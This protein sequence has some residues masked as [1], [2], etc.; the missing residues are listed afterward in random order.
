V[1]TCFKYSC[2]M[3]WALGSLSASQKGTSQG[4]ATFDEYESVGLL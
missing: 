4:T 2:Q 3:E 1:L